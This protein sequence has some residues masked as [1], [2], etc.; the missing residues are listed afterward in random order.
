MSR[1]ALDRRAVLT[2][3][4]SGA[5]SA[6]VESIRARIAKA[7]AAALPTDARERRL[8]N[9]RQLTFGGQNAE[10]YFDWTGTRLIFQSTRPPFGC[11]QIFT[12][13]DDGSD[14]RLVSTGKGRTTCSFF[15]PDG[16]RFI[17]ASTHLGGAACPPP[18]DRSRGYVWPIYPTYEIF[19]ADLDG[20]NLTRLTDNEGYDAEGAVSPDGR[21]IVF[22]SLREA[23]LDLYVMD[24]DGANVRRLTDRPGY[25]G[26]PFFSWDGRYIVFR[27]ARPETREELEGY[28]TLLKQSL[29][30]PQRLE[31]FVMKADGTGLTQVTRNGAASFAPF[32]HPNSQQIVFSSN[33][34]DPTRRAFAL[35]LVNLD[36]SGLERVTYADAF[37][38]FPMFSRDGARL[39]F[40]SD[41]NATA[42]RELNVF[43]ADWVA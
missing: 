36:G 28:R 8:A 31:L 16:K 23:D 4:L 42:P 10:A 29:V 18:P 6:L 5:A 43:L 7:S 32:M 20:R 30:R 27:A 39:V 17:Y 3:G 15:F 24:A 25:D 37:A 21:R 40:C 38:S 14:V 41:R 19:S 33:L 35:W 22:T 26:G 34:H 9:L 12:M 13:R 11:D 1:W 2:L